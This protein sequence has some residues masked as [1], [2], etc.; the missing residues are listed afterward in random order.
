MTPLVPVKDF[1]MPWTWGAYVCSQS[2]M[3]INIYMDLFTECGCLP[4][5]LLLLGRKTK[6]IT[7]QSLPEMPFWPSLSISTFHLFH[8]D[9]IGIDSFQWTISEASKE[10]MSLKVLESK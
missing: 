4:A 9:F 8:K 5:F 3:H 6:I 10:V 7:T 1:E 2:P